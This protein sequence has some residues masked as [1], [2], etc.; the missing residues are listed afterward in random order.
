[1]KTSFRVF[2]PSADDLL[3]TTIR[4]EKSQMERLD[5]KTGE[6]VKVTGAR[7]TAA[8]CLPLEDGFS[9][10]ND[11]EMT[12]LEN[13][14]ALPQARPGGIT[15]ENLNHHRMAGLG[16]IQIEKVQS[17]V[18]ERISLV[19][20][21][22]PKSSKTE[23]DKTWL[24]GLVVSKDD[25]IY[26]RNED[27]NLKFG[28]IVKDVQPEGFCVIDKDTLLEFSEDSPR[29]RRIKMNRDSFNNLTKVIPISRQIKTDMFTITVPSLE[30]YEEGLRCHLYIRGRYGD[31]MQ[32]MHSH[33]TPDVMVSDDLGN[34]YSITVNG[35]GGSMG[36][37]GFDCKW[38]MLIPPIDVDAKE[39]T[40][41]V[42]EIRWQG[43]MENPQMGPTRDM[44]KG[45]SAQNRD[46][47][48]PRYSEIEKF[49]PSMICS[50]PWEI[51]IPL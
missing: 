12:Y 51:Q 31:N 19:K 38:D 39:L 34:I 50:G 23:F 9:I 8:T 35:G 26:F 43:N 45:L 46:N 2:P 29:P 36:P 28:C 18:A 49:P 47:R 41:T 5:I 14:P 48:R 15:M 27:Y 11:P 20:V 21:S 25:R 44:R 37:D 16:P 10:P 6:I 22:N 3:S 17:S 1:M 32:F 33:V 7:T 4:I 40:L 30:I 13:T 42:Q 24:F